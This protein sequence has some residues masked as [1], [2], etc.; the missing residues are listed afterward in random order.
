MTCSFCMG[1][2][3]INEDG[4]IEKC[5]ACKGKKSVTCGVCFGTKKQIELVSEGVS[6]DFSVYCDSIAS[7]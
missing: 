2:D 3:N 6:P 7:V 5:P 4:S 1:L